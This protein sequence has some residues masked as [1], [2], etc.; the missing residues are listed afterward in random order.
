MELGATKAR[1]RLEFC[2]FDD[3]GAIPAPG[4]HPR[5]TFREKADIVREPSNVLSGDRIDHS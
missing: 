3:P 5:S 4:Q 1:L 2:P